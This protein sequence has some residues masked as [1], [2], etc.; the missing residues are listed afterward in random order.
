[1]TVYKPEV[2]GQIKDIIERLEL[3]PELITSTIDLYKK[4][5]NTAYLAVTKVRDL[6]MALACVYI[7]MRL[8]SKRP[9]T[10]DVF[11]YHYK[12]STAT[13]RKTYGLICRVMN[14][15]RTKIVGDK[16]RM[17]NEGSP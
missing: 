14:I 6:S 3:E 4:S 12:V 15:D 17:R 2:E 7:T 16:A 1:M 10:Q 5:V 13:L 9:V 8:Y 11:S